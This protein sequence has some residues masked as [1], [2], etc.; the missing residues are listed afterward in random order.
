MIDDKPGELARLLTEIG[1]IGVNLEEIKLEHS[2]RS[3]VGL[4]EVSVLPAVEATLVAALAER[5]W[6]L[7][8]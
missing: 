3:P 6:K 4:V 1:E 8:G 5:G 7:V 2:P